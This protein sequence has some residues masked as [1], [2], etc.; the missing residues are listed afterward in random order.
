MRANLDRSKA[1]AF[2][3]LVES[4]DTGRPQLGAA[5]V[6]AT[7]HRLGR[8]PGGRC[9]DVGAGTGQLTGG[10]LGSADRVVAV[11]PS[12]PMAA[13]LTARFGEAVAAGRLQVLVEPFESL[14]ADQLG[15]FDAVWSSDAWHWVDPDLGYPTA[16]TLL[17]PG[18]CLITT[19]G[20]PVLTDPA[21]QDRLNSL[22]Q[23][24]SPDLVRDPAHH[25][26][27]HLRDL[28]PLLDEGRQQVDRST[29]LRVVD[30]WTEPHQ[31]RVTPD[32]YVHW[33]LSY[34][35]IA[36]LNVPARAALADAVHAALDAAAPGPVSV[37][38]WRYTCA[39][40]P[41]IPA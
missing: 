23:R 15:V 36:D 18:G 16:A 37:T 17:D 7:L 5:Y 20:F 4:Y 14:P 22:Y 38:T 34:A 41:T 1:L 29:R 13:R 32:V 9:L 33:Q 40:E 28:T 21:L 27:H 3:T 2:G 19:W 25:P 30:H 12:P 31:V 6:T 10:L 24:V 35:H 26:A 11:E 39:S 8:A